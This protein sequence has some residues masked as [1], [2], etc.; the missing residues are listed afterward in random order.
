MGLS[1]NVF[2]NDELA[3]RQVF[4]MIAEASIAHK[5]EP[6]TSETGSFVSM[7]CR[8]SAPARADGPPITVHMLAIANKQTNTAYVFI[9]E[10]P[11]SQWDEAWK[12]GEV[13]MEN[14]TLGSDV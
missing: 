7:G 2:R 5:A 1:A 10:S 13:M 11:A 4:R 8:Y 6:F 9:F 14:L 12:R 3:P